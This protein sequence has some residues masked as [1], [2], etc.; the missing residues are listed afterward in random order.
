MKANRGNWHLSSKDNNYVIFLFFYIIF[1]TYIPSFN[2]VDAN[3][4]KFFTLSVLNLIGF[5]SLVFYKRSDRPNN[6]SFHLLHNRFFW[7]YLAFTGWITISSIFSY[8]SSESL[9]HMAKWSTIIGGLYLVTQ[10]LNRA[11]EPIK[12]LYQIGRAHV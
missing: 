2:A 6:N 10:L 5:V 1:T 9:L 4:T 8:N 12:L 3:A 7:L 11:S